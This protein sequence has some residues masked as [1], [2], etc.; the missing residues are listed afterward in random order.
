M[1]CFIPE[2]FDLIRSLRE[3]RYT[4]T[5]VANDYVL[6]QENVTVRI[7]KKGWFKPAQEQLID[8]FSWHI[9]VHHIHFAKVFDSGLTKQQNL[10]VVR[11]Y[12]PPS[13]LLT[14][15]VL[16]TT[17]TLVSTVDALCTLGRTH[18]G[19]KPS[20]IFV[21]HKDLKLADAKIPGIGLHDD[22]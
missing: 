16:R 19:I 12:L 2:R 17:R 4:K 18:G 8:H 22:A 1:K 3:D 6:D 15:D 13:E 21:A 9:G 10:Y 14:A 20:N 5:F 7:V 11:E